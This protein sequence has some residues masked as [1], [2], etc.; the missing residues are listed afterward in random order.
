M[1]PWAA[2]HENCGAH[3][4]GSPARAACVARNQEAYRIGPAYDNIESAF[5]KHPR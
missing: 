3:A 4:R 1:S 2:P 5:S